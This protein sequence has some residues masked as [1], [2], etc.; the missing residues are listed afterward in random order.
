MTTTL[1]EAVTLARERGLF[2]EEQRASEATV[3]TRQEKVWLVF[4]CAMVG[5]QLARASP[6]GI[7]FSWFV[8]LSTQRHDRT[9]TAG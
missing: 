9:I 6:E 4:I 3:N 2:L 5:C 8:M 7:R 1:A